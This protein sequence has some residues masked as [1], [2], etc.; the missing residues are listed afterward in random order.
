MQ[1]FNSTNNQNTFK[2]N[3]LTYPKNFMI[4]KQ[5][6]ENISIHN[7]YDTRFQLLGSIH[8]SQVQVNGV[9]HTSQANLMA[10]LAILLFAKQFNY[11]VQD[12][13]ATRLISIGELSIDGNYLTVEPAEWLIN[14]ENF[15]TTINTVLTVPYCTSGNNRIDIIIGN[16]ANQITRIAGTETSGIAVAPIIP[17]DCVYITEMNV[18]DNTIDITD[19]ITGSLF[20][21]KEEFAENP[22]IET[23]EYVIELNSDSSQFRFMNGGSVETVEG[24]NATSFF[25]DSLMYV[26]KEIKIVNNQETPITLVH[27]G[28]SVDIQMRFPTETDLILQPLEIAIFKIVKVAD[29]YIEFVTINRLVTAITPNLLS[30]YNNGG[31]SY[32]YGFVSSID[33]YSNLDSKFEPNGDGHHNVTF[34][35]TDGNFVT[36]YYEDIT[37][38]GMQNH[39][40]SNDLNTDIG[41]YQGIYD[42]TVTKISTGKSTHLNF[43]EPLQNTTLNLP[44]KSVAGS[45]TIAT[46]DDITASISGIRITGGTYS[47]GTT[48]LVNNTGGTISISGFSTGT[49][50]S[51]TTN[52]L[53]KFIS[54]NTIGNS[55]FYDGGSAVGGGYN[56]GV[57]NVAFIRGGNSWLFLQRAQSSLDFILG[58]P[59]SGQPNILQSTNLIDGF[60]IFSDGIFSLFAGSNY[61][62]GTQHEGLRILTG[63]TI[64]LPTTPLTGTSSDLLLVRDVS[65]NVKT[66]SVNAISRPNVTGGTY[67]NGVIVFSNS[68]GGTFNVSGLTTPFTGGTVNG[69]TTFS[70][71]ISATTISATTISA[72]TISGIKRSF[73][74]SIDGM[75]SVITIGN[76]FDV[77]VPYNMI[78]QSWNLFSDVSG[79]IVIDVWKDTY[80]N[81]PPTS[82]DTITASAKPTISASTKNQSSTLTGWNVNVSAGDII[83]F[84]VDSCTG[85]TKTQ[86][87]LTGIEI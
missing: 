29:I 72:T 85:I 83:R 3:G 84:N 28:S 17:F 13:N 76:Q 27:N 68:T 38:I 42:T 53:P 23:G 47:G 65:G 79:S 39:Y 66:L 59:G 12:V 69:T 78:L 33:G 82:A 62:I 56:T 32:P 75:G 71:G 36:N 87:T 44:A 50:F 61:Q 34:G 58:N 6:D 73:G 80:A 49:T 41:I 60:N 46:T 11:V 52:T 21:K 74:L 25:W 20:V 81:F 22:I 24:F 15:E 37:R 2:F 9:V 14:G 7:A 67:S 18:N 8:Y 26:G 16:S 4:I 30:V 48:T 55:F 64:M 86:L 10:S 40:L 43:Q 51:G 54:G 77:T 1:I 57:S 5:G 70:N 35:T 45:Y 63:G 19:P 31:E